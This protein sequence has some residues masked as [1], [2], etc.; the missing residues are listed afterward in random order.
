MKLCPQCEFLYEDD[1]VF[2]DMDGEGL[3]HDS[4]AE[5]F[6]EPAPAVA[7]ASPKQSRPRPRLMIGAVLAGLLLS[8]LLSFAYYASTRSVDFDRASP[9]RHPEPNLS[10][11]ITATPVDNSSAQPVASPTQSQLDTA[12]ESPSPSANELASP[13]SSQLGRAR[14]VTKAS[15]NHSSTG[16]SRLMI[17][18][19]LAPLPQ[20]NPLPQLPSPRRLS[21]AKPTAALPVTATSGKQK[22]PNETRTETSQKSLIVE[23]KPPSR[24]A[25]KRSKVG[26]FFKKTG[27]MLAKPFKH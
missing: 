3:V 4:R 8:A 1:Q 2:C 10:Q 23:V 25:S 7:S 14:G 21:A 26:A 19:R 17:S 12:S 22:I 16:D 6:S 13:S 11:Q 27:R 5:V 18:K 24:N 9:S 20:L 15:D